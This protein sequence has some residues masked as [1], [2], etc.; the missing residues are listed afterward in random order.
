MK[1]KNGANMAYS[2]G[3]PLV[4][5]F[6]KAGSLMEKR[7][8]YYGN[9]ASALDLFQ[10]AW[11]MDRVRAFKLALW[12]RDARSGAGNRSGSRKVFAFMAAQDPEWVKLNFDL[13]PKYGRWDDFGAFVGTL[14]EKDA[15]AYWADAISKKD[16]LAC[17]WAPRENKANKALAKAL[18][19]A[20]HLSSKEYRKHLAENTSVVETAMCSKNWGEINYSQVPSVAMSRYGKTFKAKDSARF[21]SFL[22]K[23]ADPE[24]SEKINAG[25][26]FPHD[27]YRSY[28]AGQR[29][30]ADAQFAAL[31][32]F[33][34]TGMRVMPIVDTSG[35][36]SV[37]VSGSI[38]AIDIAVS[39]A[40]Y[41]SDRLGAENPFYRKF[42]PFSTNATFVDWRNAKSF[43]EGVN[44]FSRATGFGWVGSTHIASAFNL[45]L[46]TA[47]FLNVT[48]EQMPNVILVI[49]DMQF[50]SG[51]T[52]SGT[53]LQNLMEIW[54]SR[55]Y[56][57]P[58]I[59]YWNT[60]GNAGSPDTAYSNNI[61]F[62]SGFSPSILKSVFSGTDFTP[63]GIMNTTLENYPIKMLG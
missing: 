8:Q 50:N 38:Q 30:V 53:E 1:T 19:A 2:T 62:V 18:R 51:T 32:T 28:K 16:G 54:K 15:L 34:E 59:V 7:K 14:L 35:S 22:E 29:A 23:V 44:A 6:S 27:V 37:N 49:S 40:L 43:S 63:E 11:A 45:L 9:E 31:P 17:K 61:G 60:A 10:N 36:M 26:L 42:I 25:A 3:N 55:G 24:S 12:L 48:N 58:K 57:V 56:D 33:F 21:A 39:L 41:A 47:S 20:L 5:F 4:E 52:G 46:D 13:I